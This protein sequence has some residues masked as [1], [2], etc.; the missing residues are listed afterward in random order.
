[1]ST[2]K[3]KAAPATFLNVHPCHSLVA[4]LQVRHWRE[5]LTVSL[6]PKATKHALS[7]SFVVLESVTALIKRVIPQLH[8]LIKCCNPLHTKR[9]RIKTSRL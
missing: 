7:N 6:R 1:M 2:S 5:M 8:S 9:V 3:H 4:S